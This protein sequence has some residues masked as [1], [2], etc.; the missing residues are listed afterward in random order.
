MSG[1]NTFEFLERP[2]QIA[3]GVTLPVGGYDFSTAAVSYTL[4]AQRRLGGTTRVEHG[5][6]YNGDK[7][8][9]AFSGGR[10]EVTNQLQLQPG[11]SLNWV[12]LPKG[13][14]TAQQIQTRAVYTMS[15]RAFLA[16][17]VQYNSGDD[18]LSTNLRL[19]W[20]YRPGSELFVVYNDQRNTLADG[21]PNL[22]NRAFIIKLA[23]LLRF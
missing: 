19:R 23:P 4:G 6:F 12:R 16:A 2:F 5:T 7:T 11:I 18:A 15:P 21:F 1:T 10:F 9:L 22:V 3:D 17:L 20:E 8:T 14:F 13:D